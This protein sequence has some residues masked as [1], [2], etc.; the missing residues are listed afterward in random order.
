MPE[1]WLCVQGCGACCHLEPDDRPDLSDYLSAAELELYLSMVGEGGWCI[2]FDH[3]SRK[4][5]IYDDRPRFC[6]VLPDTF[7]AMFGVLVEDFNEFAIDCCREQIEGVYG[8]ESPEME[9][10]DQAVLIDG[11]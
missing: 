4:C 11:L 10:F 5:Q 2:N 1:Q 6:R 8:E 9:R 7:E 3:Q